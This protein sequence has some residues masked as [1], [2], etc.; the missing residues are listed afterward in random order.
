LIHFETLS[1]VISDQKSHSADPFYA[2]W[3][4]RGWVGRV[5]KAYFDSPEVGLYLFWI[6][7]FKK[8]IIAIALL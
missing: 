6:I 4:V 7:I 5:V 2:M 1:I 8:M 3:C